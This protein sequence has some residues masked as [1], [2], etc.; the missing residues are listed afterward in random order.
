MFVNTYFIFSANPIETILNL[1]GTEACACPRTSRRRSYKCKKKK[2]SPWWEKASSRDLGFWRQAS[3]FPHSAPG[4]QACRSSSG[5]CEP[6]SF[7]RCARKPSSR[8]SSGYKQNHPS[9]EGWFCLELL[10]RFEL[11]TSSLPR[12]C[13]TSW[14]IAAYHRI[15]PVTHYIISKKIAFVNTFLEK[16]KYIAIFFCEL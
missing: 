8:G 12:M 10:P 11:G 7:A 3:I 6:D 15:F 13:S 2:L 16:N 5:K 9:N 14:A 4:K 1:F